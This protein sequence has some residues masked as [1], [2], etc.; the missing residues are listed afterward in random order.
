[1][2]TF[3]Q[4]FIAHRGLYLV[5][6]KACVINGHSYDTMREAF[7][8]AVSNMVK[9]PELTEQNNHNISGDMSNNAGNTHNDEDKTNLMMQ[10]GNAICLIN[11]YPP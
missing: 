1:M 11:T 8:D 9:I 7:I 6:H 10:R 5:M 3:C 4:P 2:A